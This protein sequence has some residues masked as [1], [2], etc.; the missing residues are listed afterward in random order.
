MRPP[1]DALAVG[2][3]IEIGLTDDRVAWFPSRVE[4]YD[5]DATLMLAWPTDG[6][7]RLVRLETDQRL[8]VATCSRDAMYLA[9]V[10]VERLS[11]GDV[12]LVTVRVSGAWERSQRR[13]AVRTRVAIRPRIADRVQA[14]TRRR[15]RLGLTNI[16]A[17]GVQVRSSDELR[18]GDLLDLAFELMGL[19]G[20]I[21]LQARVCRLQRNERVWEA[22]CEFEGI[23]ERVAR[24][25]VQFI[26]AEE[27]AQARARLAQP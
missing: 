26:F 8:E 17:T 16:S 13:N 10:V 5:P 25:I 27:R 18:R 22:G 15:L 12:P 6:E 14:D 20:E 7:R 21:Q 23:S 3:H 11:T 1:S 19:E 9:T 4:D 24:R 2:H